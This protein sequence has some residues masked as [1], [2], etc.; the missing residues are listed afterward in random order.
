MAFVR[1]FG[2]LGSTS[3]TRV[4]FLNN[5]LYQISSSR[6]FSSSGYLAAAAQSS[7]IQKAS[8]TTGRKDPLDTK[9]SDPIAAFKS[10]TTFELIRGYVVYMLC[11]S[12]FLVEN[13]MK[14]GSKD[15][16]R[17][18]PDP[19]KFPIAIFNFLVVSQSKRKLL[20]ICK[21]FHSSSSNKL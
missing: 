6:V 19:D 17:K 8:P 18:T 14:V 16:V 4:N 3:A 20:I 2:K 13:N 21:F 1:F 12:S 15:Q 10:K 5:N 11:S 7:P 9:F